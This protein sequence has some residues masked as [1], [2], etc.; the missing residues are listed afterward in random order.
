MLV[1]PLP[2]YRSPEGLFID[3]QAYN[4]LHHW[5]TNFGKMILCLPELPIASAPANVVPLPPEAFDG[6]YRIV[7]LPDRRRPIGF[8][9]DLASVTRTL[10]AALDESTHRC[11][12]IGGLFGDWGAVAALRAHRKRLASSVWA[13]RVESQVTRFAA[14][15]SHG[16]RKLLRLSTAIAMKY[17]ERAVIR[18]TALGLFHGADCYEA[19]ARFSASPHIVHNIHLSSSARISPDALAAKVEHR[20]G[21][22]RIVYAGRAHAEKG[23]LDWV[24]TLRRI[25]AQGVAF[26]A[27]WYGDGPDLAAARAA[28]SQAGLERQIA[29]PG[30]MHDRSALMR[31]LREADMFLFCHK[32][33]E[34]PR[35]LIEALISGT[36]IIGYDSAYPRDL[37]HKHQGGRLTE[38]NPTALADA[39]VGLTADKMALGALTRN[40]AADGYPFTDEEVFRHRADLIRAATDDAGARATRPDRKQTWRYANAM[41]GRA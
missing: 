11:F 14:Q 19:Y 2:V 17:F 35:C 13:D 20:R 36:P 12:A 31:A 6:R 34:S 38:G 41:L 25:A 15:H 24:E 32:T 23:V 16:P 9:R 26:D 40:A 27:T 4:G 7:C 39:V 33:P 30:A 3:A 22:M 28:V 1:L 29:F 5:L 21:P 10:D 18:R 37:I 8:F